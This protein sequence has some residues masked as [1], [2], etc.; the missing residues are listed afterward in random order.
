[1]QNYEEDA[2]KPLLAVFDRIA[3]LPGQKV[4][5]ATDSPHTMSLLAHVYDTAVALAVRSGSVAGLL[6]LVREVS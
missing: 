4:S 3:S 2:V 1:L 5:G 6:T